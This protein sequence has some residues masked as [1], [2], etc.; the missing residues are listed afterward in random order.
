MQAAA[1]L[2]G[3]VAPGQCAAH[4]RCCNRAVVQLL[5]VHMLCILT[6]QPLRMLCNLPAGGCEGCQGPPH[7]RLQRLLHL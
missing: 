3:L 5:F 7:A 4:H 6:V 1:R 2:A